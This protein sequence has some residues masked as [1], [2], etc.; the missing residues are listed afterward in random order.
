[1]TNQAQHRTLH[2]HP[3]PRSDLRDLAAHLNRMIQAGELAICLEINAAESIARFSYLE[4]DGVQGIALIAKVAV[5]DRVAV[6]PK[7]RR[8]GSPR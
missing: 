8:N 1:M 5:G 4:A 2:A 6:S 3:A 7:G